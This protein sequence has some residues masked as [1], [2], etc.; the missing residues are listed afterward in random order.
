MTRSKNCTTGVVARG[1]LRFHSTPS[2]SSRQGVRM[3]GGFSADEEKNKFSGGVSVATNQGGKGCYP[4]GCLETTVRL[5]LVCLFGCC[6]E[7]MA[8]KWIR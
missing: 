6:K 5:E 4:D 8:K 7:K 2:V 3:S 1:N